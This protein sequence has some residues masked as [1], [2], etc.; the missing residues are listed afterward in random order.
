MRATADL[1]EI[2]KD[3]LSHVKRGVG[4]VNKSYVVVRDEL[5]TQVRALSLSQIEDLSEAFLD[6]KAVDDLKQWLAE[7]SGSDDNPPAATTETK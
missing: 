5:E 2:Y 1:T 7:H 3:E 6:F 4:I